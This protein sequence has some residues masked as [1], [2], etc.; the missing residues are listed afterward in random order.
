AKLTASHTG[1][2]LAAHRTAKIHLAVSSGAVA[3]TLFGELSV[4]LVGEV[5]RQVARRAIKVRPAPKKPK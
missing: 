1:G 3:D 4:N 5:D 2:S